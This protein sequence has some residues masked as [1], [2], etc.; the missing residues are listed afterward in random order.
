MEKPNGTQDELSPSEKRTPKQRFGRF[1]EVG[2]AL[3]A[4]VGCILI[5]GW[6]WEFSQG[7]NILSGSTH[8]TGPGWV[9]LAWGIITTGV[10]VAISV[11]GE[12]LNKSRK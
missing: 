12:K 2:G 1:L 5:I 9:P 3:C 7:C 10:G 4:G 8:Y 6:A 11:L